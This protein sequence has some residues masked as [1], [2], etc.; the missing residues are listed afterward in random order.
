MSDCDKIAVNMHDA[1]NDCTFAAHRKTP[2]RHDSCMVAQ[3]KIHPNCAQ[4]PPEN[5]AQQTSNGHIYHPPP[6]CHTV[7]ELCRE[8]V[9]CR[10][11]LEHFEQACAIDSV[12]KKC[13]GRTSQ[14]RLAMLGILGTS[15]RTT[16]AC[17]GAEAHQL[18][19]CL[20]WQ[21][22]LWL[23]PCVGE[24][25]KIMAMLQA[26]I[27][28]F[29]L[30]GCPPRAVEAQKDFHMKRLAEL[31]L[32]PTTTTTAMPTLRTTAATIPTTTRRTTV[33]TTV[34]VIVV[35]SVGAQ[36]EHRNANYLIYCSSKT[37]SRRHRS[38]RHL[39]HR[40]FPRI[41]TLSHRPVREQRRWCSTRRTRKKAA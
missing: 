23:N 4:R 36:P 5:V 35:S 40:P 17:Q 19:E 14:C 25:V 1:Y 31:G 39:S 24:S 30:I 29:R 37:H 32:L 3:E 7:A 28:L 38:H 41:I 12:T 6:G 22:L 13:A 8:E 2:N 11:R 9:N 33:R 16:C 34:Q 20:G 21:R 26:L 18:Y 10:P 27:L 15:L